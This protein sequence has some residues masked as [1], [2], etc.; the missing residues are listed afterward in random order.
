MCHVRVVGRVGRD[1]QEHCP[2][3]TDALRCG[4]ARTLPRTGRDVTKASALCGHL[5]SLADAAMA[6][7]GRGR[8]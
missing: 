3:S 4:G 7:N 2:V 8:Q 1:E 5:R 6:E